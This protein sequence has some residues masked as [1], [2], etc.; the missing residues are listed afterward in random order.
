MS[1]TRTRR[2]KRRD[3]VQPV[4]TSGSGPQHRKPKRAYSSVPTDI[5]RSLES[6]P[7]KL[8]KPKEPN[9]TSS[10]L[11]QAWAPQQSDPLV[12][13]LVDDLPFRKTRRNSEG[14]RSPRISHFDPESTNNQPRRISYDPLVDTPQEMAQRRE[15]HPTERR[16]D[17]VEDHPPYREPPYQT[18]ELF[19]SPGE[20]FRTSSLGQNNQPNSTERRTRRD[21]SPPYQTP[22]GFSRSPSLDPVEYQM[23]LNNFAQHGDGRNGHDPN[24]DTIVQATS[25]DEGV[26]ENP[27]YEDRMGK[28]P[29]SPDPDP[30][31]RQKTMGPGRRWKDLAAQTKNIQLPSSNPNF[32]NIVSVGL[33]YNLPISDKDIDEYMLDRRE[34]QES[35]RANMKA[36][37]PSSIKHGGKSEAYARKS[38]AA[39]RAST[40][41]NLGGR[42]R[43]S[44]TLGGRD[45]LAMPGPAELKKAQ[46]ILKNMANNTM[47]MAD[48][49][50][51]IHEIKTEVENVKDIG[52]KGWRL[53]WILFTAS[54]WSWLGRTMFNLNQSTLWALS[55]KELAGTHGHHVG[56]YFVFMRWCL[57]INI[58]L[59]MM[60]TLFVVVPYTTFY[61]FDDP[62][63]SSIIDFTDDFQH[64]TMTDN[65]IGVFT[66]GGWLNA[67]A[68]FMGSYNFPVGNLTFE[69]TDQLA[70][71]YDVRLAYMWV[72]FGYLMFSFILIF[73]G[74]RKQ[75]GSQLKRKNHFTDELPFALFTRF[76]Y[77]LSSKS[78]I[79]IRKKEISVELLTYHNDAEKRAEYAEMLRRRFWSL[80]LKRLAINIAV[81]VLLVGALAGVFF[82]FQRFGSSTDPTQKLIPA[83]VLAVTNAV[84]PFIFEIL[85]EL[86]EW[87]TPL[88]VIQL[89]IMRSV[90]LRI[91]GF[92]VALYA[93]YVRRITT[94]C[95]ESFVGQEMYT[96]FV[97]GSFVFE[98]ITSGLIDMLLTTLYNHFP[99]VRVVLKTPAYF[100]SIKKTL[101]LVY[102]QGIIW[103]GS[104][105]CPLLPWVGCFRIVVLF[106]L[107]KWSTMTWCKPKD[108]PFASKYSLPNMVWFMLLGAYVMAMVP[109]GYTFTRLESSGGYLNPVLDDDI[110][111][112]HQRFVIFD[113]DVLV[114]YPSN[115][116]AVADAEVVFNCVKC[117]ESNLDVQSRNNQTVCWNYIVDL[118]GTNTAGE[119]V[120][121]LYD[122][123]EACPPG[124]GPFRNQESA[125]ATLIDMYREWPDEVKQVF[126]FLGTTTFTVILGFFL[127][128][129]LCITQ[130]R[131]HRREKMLDKV[132][133][134]LAMERLDRRYI[135]RHY[136]PIN[137]NVM[138][139][140]SANEHGLQQRVK[141]AEPH[142][143][144]GFS[145]TAE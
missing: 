60:W 136:A 64:N 79:K 84:C 141:N 37:S 83:L 101:E 24:P 131:N 91:V 39:R 120:M 45:I 5:P 33:L 52:I 38:E 89:S 49:K 105:F 35:L 75:I 135:M 127:I 3:F 8:W 72:G 134:E 145:A 63:P 124:C 103:F 80:M 93:I 97:V 118:N 74:V 121:S 98:I 21:S 31:E 53:R 10:D 69:F 129:L 92:Y 6:P 108:T 54:V 18:P 116:S 96:I 143:F 48:K 113:N 102:A 41:R 90:V 13:P 117:V 137:P 130:A 85:A 144:H 95:W 76:D 122:F 112:W 110:R 70:D 47:A 29:V 104:A 126:I 111:T 26:V 99:R 12:D 73:L 61:R 81:I 87:P 42:G 58:Y 114:L 9:N 66:G 106:Y 2:S 23:E 125:Y 34:R 57:I 123:C 17:R 109:I 1:F 11:R 50:E 68:L 139:M 62:S 40:P 107:Q 55:I 94:G 56:T 20:G 115:C 140:S 133:L 51:K 142:Q 128:S 36:K 59:G 44:L 43:S 28:S 119:A 86:E 19:Q 15:T 22:P 82:S 78:S 7:F 65:V 16:S 30:P 77:S 88:A 4:V 32:E 27:G 67:T 46:H 71:I 100:D 25:L 132:E 14:I 138:R